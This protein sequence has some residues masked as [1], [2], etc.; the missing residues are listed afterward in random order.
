MRLC[1]FTVGKC[2]ALVSLHPAGSLLL[3]CGA[4]KN[5]GGN[6]PPASTFS[7][8]GSRPGTLARAPPGMTPAVK[9]RD[10]K[11]LFEL[12]GHSQRRPP[13]GSSCI[14]LCC[15]L[16]WRLPQM[17]M[18]YRRVLVLIKER[19]HRFVAHSCHFRGTL[20]VETPFILTLIFQT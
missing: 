3:L 18:G 10:P 11:V 1:L 6:S 4:Q 7:S 2:R 12:R 8:F 19:L 9:N 16:R 14:L 5:L 17:W 13:W 15:S 20:S